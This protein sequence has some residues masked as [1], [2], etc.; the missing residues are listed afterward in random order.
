MLIILYE[1]FQIMDIFLWLS[2]NVIKDVNKGFLWTL[3]K[4]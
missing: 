1:R 2:L 4:R 3:K